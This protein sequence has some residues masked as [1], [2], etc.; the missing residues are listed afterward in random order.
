MVDWG[1]AL[2]VGGVGFITVFVVLGILSI[3]MWLVSIIMNKTINRPKKSV[4]TKEEQT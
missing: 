2:R 3:V 1:Q 4:E